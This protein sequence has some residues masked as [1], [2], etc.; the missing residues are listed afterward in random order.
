MEDSDTA[1]KLPASKA[2]RGEHCPF[3]D[4]LEQ[5]FDTN[6]DMVIWIPDTANDMHNPYIGNII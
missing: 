2:D 4:V 3:F 1:T 5:V 6:L